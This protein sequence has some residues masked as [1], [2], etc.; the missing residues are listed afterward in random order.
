MTRILNGVEGGNKNTLLRSIVTTE[1]GEKVMVS[2]VHLSI[3]HGDA[4]IPLWYETMV[5]LMDE[6]GTQIVEWSELDCDRYETGDEALD[7]HAEMVMKWFN[8]STIHTE[9]L[10]L[11]SGEEN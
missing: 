6:G 8:D 11:T 2:T 1:A 5:F 9:P 10:M 4:L 7:G 3:N